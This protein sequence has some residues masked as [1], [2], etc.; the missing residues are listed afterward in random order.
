M[1]R[2]GQT[3]GRYTT[4]DGMG[5]TIASGA[6]TSGLHERLYWFLADR[7]LL[8]PWMT[9]QES[10]KHV[11]LKVGFMARTSGTGHVRLAVNKPV[12]QDPWGCAKLLPY[13]LK[14]GQKLVV[15]DPT[16]SYEFEGVGPE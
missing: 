9:Q 12:C 11:E 5:D 13:V 14:P 4:D 16:G 6:E 10:T 1:W 7:R 15:T 8:P 2:V 3:T